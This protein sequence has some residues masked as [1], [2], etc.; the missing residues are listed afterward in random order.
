MNTIS[1]YQLIL[2]YPY[3]HFFFKYF[4]DTYVERKPGESSNDRN[5]RAI[6]EATKWY[7]MHIGQNQRNKNEKVR[8]ILLTDDVGNRTKAIEQGILACSVVD[9]V[10]SMQNHPGLQDKLSCRNFDIET[11]KKPIYPIHYTPSHIHD[12]IKK[13]EVVQGTFLASRDNYL[14]G[15]VNV[16][17]YEK[18]V[19]V[20]G[21][22]SLNRAVDGDIVAV[23]LFPE[24]K[25]K[26]PSDVI[27]QD[28]QEDPGDILEEEN[29]DETVVKTEAEKTPTGRVIGI[30][31]RKW[32]QYCGILLPNA[33]KGSTRHI[34]VPAERKIPRVRIETRQADH[35]LKQ[36]IIVAIDQWPR[37]SRY[38]VGHFVRALGPLGDKETEN[39]VLLIEHDVPH[40]KFSEE[41][42]SFLPKMPWTINDEVKFYYLLIF[43]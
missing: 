11:E 34:F 23:E 30:I 10:K 4:R 28:E 2:C 24:D 5:D 9:Y 16:E 26:A 43:L 38:P 15:F 3:L 27:L 32:R 1:K 42:L 14:E 40:S 6:R 33:V 41:V 37:H 20:H 18:F 29:E 39:E 36:R 35:L 25:W 19:L 12:C 22:E 13:G 31:R 17:G 21:R 7:D 8:V